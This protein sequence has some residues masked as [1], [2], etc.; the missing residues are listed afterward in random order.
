MPITEK[1]RLARMKKLGSS[2]APAILGVSP[3]KTAT[4]VYWEKEVEQ[5]DSHDGDTDR[6]DA[7]RQPS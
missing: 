1:Q 6:R 3:W 2:D 4:D 7:D 5:K